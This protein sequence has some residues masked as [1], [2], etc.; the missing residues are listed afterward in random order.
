MRVHKET[1]FTTLAVHSENLAEAL[2]ECACPYTQ[3]V[4]I[5]R[6]T[7]CLR[8]LRPALLEP[9]PQHLVVSLTVT[10]LPTAKPV[11]E[12]DSEQLCD[13]ALAL[14]QLLSSQNLTPAIHHTLTGLLADLVELFAGQLSAPRWLS[15]QEGLVLI[16]E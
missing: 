4:L 13:Y 3:Q 16:G 12:P 14:S 10:S 7:T 8:I 11:F 6:L 5:K 2:L 15:T 1:D 9:I